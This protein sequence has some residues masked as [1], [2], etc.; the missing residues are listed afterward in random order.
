MPRRPYASDDAILQLNRWQV[1]GA[2]LGLGI[3]TVV[4][5]FAGVVVGRESS[6][7]LPP[8]LASIGATAPSGTATMSHGERARAMAALKHGTREIDSDLA[9]PLTGVVPRDKTD[10]AR[11]ET[12]RQLQ[13]S[14][15][16]GL[17]GVDGVAATP[18]GAQ[19]LVAVAPAAAVASTDDGK[20]GYT[21][22]VSAF[23]VKVAADAV[24][25]ELTG[26]GYPARIREVRANGRTFW[27]VEVGFFESPNAASAYQGRFERQ[28]GY[29]T[30]MVP[31]P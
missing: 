13:E 4:V 22:Q 14:R 26:G 2:V 15:S 5:F 25:G 7:P 17:A 30:V 20:S 16:A 29:K 6:A 3:I 1:T 21:L 31:V 12:H 18:N 23:E 24:T 28:S 8:V 9:R 11:V 27:R 10:A 19:P